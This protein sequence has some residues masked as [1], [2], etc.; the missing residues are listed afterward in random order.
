MSLILFCIL[1]EMGATATGAGGGTPT[2]PVGQMLRFG[3]GR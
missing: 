2:L 1:L 3:V